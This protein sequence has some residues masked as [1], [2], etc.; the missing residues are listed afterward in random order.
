MWTVKYHSFP[1]IKQKIQKLFLD[2]IQCVFRCSCLV[3]KLQTFVSVCEL[4]GQL[5][6]I[7][8]TNKNLNF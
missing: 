4:I 1:K 3:V 5:S 7:F 2:D 8:K 6:T